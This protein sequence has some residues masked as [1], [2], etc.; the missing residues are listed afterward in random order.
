MPRRGSNIYK[1]KDGRWEGRLKKETKTGKKRSYRSVYGKTYGEVKEKMIQLQKSR[2]KEEIACTCTIEE[3]IFIWMEDHKSCWKATTYATYRQ[4]VSKHILP[5]LGKVKAGKLNNDILENFVITKRSG[6]EGNALSNGY[7]HNVCSVLLQALS[8]GKKRYG[9]AMEIPEFSM[10][11]P[12]YHTM[13]LPGEKKLAALEEYLLVHAAGDTTSLGILL[14]AYTGIRIGELCALTWGDISTEEEVIYIRRNMQ[15]V[16]QFDGPKIYT[17]VILQTPKTLKSERIIPIPNLLMELL[18]KQ[19]GE[20]EEFMIRGKKAKWAEPRT[21]QYRFARILRQCGIEAF[22]FHKLR[23]SFATRCISKGF[24]IKSLSEILGHS[25]VQ[26]TLNLYVH[27][28]LQ[29]KKQLM[30]LFNLYLH[31]EQHS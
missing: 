12:E 19:K 1:R 15:R 17:R 4:M 21:V 23:H 28:T 22:N 3:I 5:S 18:K 7:L 16:K 25:N 14:A 9:Y 26:I 30:N 20:P 29:Q 13:F 10:P 24:D 8:Y 11:K 31:Q 27:S 2:V 6:K